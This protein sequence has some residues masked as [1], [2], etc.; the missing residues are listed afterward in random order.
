MEPKKA[1]EDLIAAGKSEA[2]IAAEINQLAGEQAITQPTVNR[3]KR[4][5]SANPGYLAVNL[6]LQVHSAVFERI[7]T[8]HGVLASEVG[9]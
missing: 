4:G 1:I 9:E 6:L 5:R 3:I 2:W 7:P 8:R